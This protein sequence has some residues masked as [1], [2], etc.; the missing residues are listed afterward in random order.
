MVP[1]ARLPFPYVIEQEVAL[2]LTLKNFKTPITSPHAP[3]IPLH[4]DHPQLR[5][6]HAVKFPP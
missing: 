1:R 4:A 3:C 6:A 2:P 5:S